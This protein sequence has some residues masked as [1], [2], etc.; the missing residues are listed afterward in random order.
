MTRKLSFK[1]G[2]GKGEHD[3]EQLILEREERRERAK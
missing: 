3:N 1:I 2:S